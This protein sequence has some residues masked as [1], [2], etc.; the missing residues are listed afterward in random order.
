MLSL[1]LNICLMIHV[2]L[3]AVGAQ[4]GEFV[5]NIQSLFK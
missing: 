1:K 3:H 4:S 5:K 2:F